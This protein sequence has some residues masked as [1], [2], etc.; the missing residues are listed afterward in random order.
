MALLVVAGAV[1]P[2]AAGC[3]S[4][5][6]YPLLMPAEAATDLFTHLETEAL[7]RRYPVRRG[8]DWIEVS[9]PEGDTLHFGVEGQDR[10]IVLAVTVNARASS[11]EETRLRHEQRKKLGDELVDAAKASAAR[12][13]AHE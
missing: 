8:G 5:Q 11:A 2:L 7:A 10:L 6:R 13:R 12:G 4:T 1:D 9:L 3:G